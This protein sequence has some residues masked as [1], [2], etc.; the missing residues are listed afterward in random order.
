M[1]QGIS[2][3]I[4]KYVEMAMS[5]AKLG[6]TNHWP[7]AKV[8]SFFPGKDGKVHVVRIRTATSTYKRPITKLAHNAR[9]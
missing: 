1:V 4:A 5:K 2:A 9:R 8:I 6:F 3:T 7:L